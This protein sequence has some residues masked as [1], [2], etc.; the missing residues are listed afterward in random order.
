MS[1]SPLTAYR[2]VA[3][4]LL[5]PGGTYALE[6]DG[7]DRLLAGTRSSLIEL[8]QDCVDQFSAQDMIEADGK[9]WTFQ[10]ILTQGSRLGAALQAHHGIQSGDRVVLNMRNRV[11][12]FIAFIAVTRVGGIAALANS[13][14]RGSE[15]RYQVELVDA[16]III[17]DRRG[18]ERLRE[19][20]CQIPIVSTEHLDREAARGKPNTE[21][22]RVAPEDPAAIIFT[23]GTTGR[24]KGATLTHRNLT[25]A[26][27]QVSYISRLGIELSARRLNMVADEVQA[28]IPSPSLLLSF[29][30]FHISG[31]TNF[32]VSITSGALIT[33]LRRWDPD[34]AIRLVEKNRIT[35]VQG[36][37]MVLKDLLE[38]PDAAERMTSLMAV[39]VGGQATPLSLT[40]LVS[41][42]LPR[43]GQGTGWGMTEVSGA[44]SSANGEVFRKYPDSCGVVLPLIDL[45]ITG[46]DNQPSSVNE[47]G[48]IWVRGA[49]VINGYWN[50]PA[51][52][53]DSF[54]NGW[55]KTGDIGRLSEH[56]LLYMV[57]RQKDMV[58][59]AGENIYCAEVEQ[60]LDS[61]GLFHEVALYGVPD[62]R[63]GEKTVA[64]VVLRPHIVNDPSTVQA[65]LSEHLAD[66][67]VPSE[68]IFHDNP[69][70]RN[71]LG[72][73]DKVAL[74]RHYKDQGYARNPH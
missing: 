9:R 74:R 63:L 60:A 56:G 50:D 37:S 71:H 69:L 26:V 35:A 31:L 1:Q 44:G 57:D 66:Y 36:P 51:A 19:A 73:V 70:P 33:L 65:K 53:V 2:E 64:A 43:A 55:F 54:E 32:L 8:Y 14:A 59:C 46:P 16:R 5:A 24:P 10:E 15:M 62:E 52:N 40:Q 68:I 21:P 34:E 72:K 42:K 49:T 61:L 30:L 29:P 67:K 48:E 17:A 23:S 41:Q 3:D 20:G 4:T 38:R 58:I 47:P 12:W 39:T 25:A 22:A 6:G 27:R 45:Q 7:N 11:E 13:R 28:S 18:A